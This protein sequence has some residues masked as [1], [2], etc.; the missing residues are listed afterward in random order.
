MPAPGFT[1]DV[2]PIISGHCA[3]CHAPGGMAKMF[4]FQSYGQ[5]GP[6]AGD[7]KLQLETCAMPLPP[8]P[9]LTPAERQ[10]LFGWILCGALNN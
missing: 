8:E 3:K 2:A 7:I 6:F 1:A 5:I 10:T 9:A 4:P